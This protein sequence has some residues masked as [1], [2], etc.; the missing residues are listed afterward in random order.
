[1]RRKRMHPYH[2]AI[3][4]SI[5]DQYILSLYC[6]P[7]SSTFNSSHVGQLIREKFTVKVIAWKGANGGHFEVVSIKTYGVNRYAQSRRCE[8][9][10]SFKVVFILSA[11]Y[12]EVH[13]YDNLRG[14]HLYGQGL[15]SGLSRMLGKSEIAGSNPTLAFQV[16]KKQSVSSLL[17]VKIQYCGEPLWSKGSVLGHRPPGLEFRILCLE[18]CVISF[19]SPS[20]GGSPG[21]L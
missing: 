15:C 16:S 10:V 1:M 21:P 11:Q 7:G 17:L 12:L 14:H 9:N 5:Y 6:V 2:S 3:F 4:L 20:P 13:K 18:G 19:S 8:K